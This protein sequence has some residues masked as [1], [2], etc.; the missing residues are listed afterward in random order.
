MTLTRFS[1]AKPGTS[2]HMFC[3]IGG[4]TK[5]FQEAGWEVAFG[6]NHSARNIET[7]G[8]NFPGAETLCQDMDRYDMRNLPQSQTLFASPICWEIAPSGGRPRK[9]SKRLTRGQLELLEHGP[10]A[11]ETWE[12][13]RATAYD[14]LRAAEVWNYDAICWENVSEF[15]TDWPLFHWWIQAL[16]ILGYNHV[17][18]SVSAAHIA[19]PDNESSPQWR[20][21]AVGAFVKKGIPLPDLTPRPL[22]KCTGCCEDVDA[23]QAWKD[24]TAP[25]WGKF[26]L[27]YHYVSPH[28][29]CR[30]PVVKPYVRP[31]LEV[32][33]WSNLG[34]TMSARPNGYAP[35][36]IAR[37][38]RGIADHGFRDGRPE[39]F[40]T[41]LRKNC[42]AQSVREPL[43]T[44][45]SK[46]NHHW[47]TTPAGADVTVEQLRKTLI[48][49]YYTN[50]VPKTVMAPLDTLTTRD[51]HWLLTVAP[52]WQDCNYRRLTPREQALAQRFPSD[53][54]MTGNLGEQTAGVGNAVPV[55]VG[56][57]LGERVRSVLDG[58]KADRQA[59]AA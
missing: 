50:G 32:V 58:A 55:N 16:D 53:Y 24:P 28:T 41:I 52:R 22:A 20:D 47:I 8:A 29:R 33:D 43:G 56:R 57:W 27:D 26:G 25:R 2:G 46:G 14:I 48:S 7:F 10:V 35:A 36:T 30:Q 39:P 17:G 23:I 49:P 18:A 34:P 31:V 44:V 11:Q 13:T 21:R 59:V 42:T 15:A 1:R 51:R 12:R 5:G 3:G 37:V 40:V 9:R 6:A 45:T 54:V 19:G 38:E 4:D